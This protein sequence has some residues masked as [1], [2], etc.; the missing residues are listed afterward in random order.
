MPYL[1]LRSVKRFGFGA[2]T[3]LATETFSWPALAQELPE[4][5]GKH[6]VESLCVSCHS[7][8]RILGT[9]GYDSAEEWRAVMASMVEL[10]DPQ[11]DTMARYLAEHFPA[12][13][14]RKPRIVDGDAAISITEWMVPTLG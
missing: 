6:L 7:T 13:A 5:E 2:L 14:E 10:A 4:G 8:T 11:A 1:H 3:L 12:R 9:G